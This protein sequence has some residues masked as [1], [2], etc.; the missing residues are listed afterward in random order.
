VGGAGS[1]YVAEHHSAHQLRAHNSQTELRVSDLHKAFGTIVA[2]EGVTVAVD[3]GEV[4]GLLGRNGAGK[5][6]TIACIS[7][8][9]RPDRGRVELRGFPSHGKQQ[10]GVSTQELALYPYLSTAANLRFCCQLAG[11]EGRQVDRRVGEA[12]ELFDL[13]SLMHR[14][15]R[16]LSGGQQRLVHVASSVVSRPRV[17]LLDEPTEG[18]DVMARRV[19]LAA[20]RELTRDGAAVLYSSHQLAEVED[21]CD[22]V[23]ILHQGRQAAAGPISEIL[24]HHGHGYCEVVLSDGKVIR[25]TSTLPELLG[26]LDIARVQAARVARPSLESVFVD[27]TST[28]TAEGA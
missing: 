17:V 11:V 20:V 2:V 15:V 1:R 27:L 26:S 25:S 22:R 14:R 16:D 18:L 23:L 4:V 7:G 24:Q 8:L 5:T 6:T 19:M 10:V 21:L 12:A 13:G 9:L 28:P 3:A